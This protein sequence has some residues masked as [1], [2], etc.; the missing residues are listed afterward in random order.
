[1]ADYPGLSRR[2]GRTFLRLP[3]GPCR[4]DRE[5]IE[6]ARQLVVG[7]DRAL[8]Q[9]IGNPFPYV[10]MLPFIDF[11]SRACACC[12]MTLLTASKLFS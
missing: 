1:M 6:W 3:G 5:A 2:R 10:P 11:Y 9:G 12:A 4:D 8:V 7:C